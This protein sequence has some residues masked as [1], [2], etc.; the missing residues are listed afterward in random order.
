ML[1][2]KCLISSQFISLYYSLFQLTQLEILHIARNPLNAVPDVVSSLTSLKQ[3]YMSRCGISSLPERFVCHM[4]ITISQYFYYLLLNY[5]YTPL[6]VYKIIY[7][8]QSLL[9]LLVLS[10][11]FLC[12]TISLEVTSQKLLKKLTYYTLLGSHSK[13]VVILDQN[14]TLYSIY[15]IRTGTQVIAQKQIDILNG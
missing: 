4:F 7:K 12:Y 1:Y 2:A 6:K 9:V 14:Y 15:S 11:S 10:L 8:I 5:I 13:T 3:L